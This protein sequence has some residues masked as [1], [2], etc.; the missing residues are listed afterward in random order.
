M[1]LFATAAGGSKGGSSEFRFNALLQ[2]TI[3]H[4]NYVR[5]RRN[6]HAIRWRRCFNVR[7]K[8]VKKEDNVSVDL[9][10]G[11]MGI[12]ITK[13]LLVVHLVDFLAYIF[14]DFIM[15]PDLVPHIR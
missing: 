1:S 3:D 7:R 12:L 9:R 2:V 13:L 15:V 4:F 5:C 8:R 14:F 11:R 10:K 6:Y